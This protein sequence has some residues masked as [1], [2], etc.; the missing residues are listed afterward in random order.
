MD[1]GSKAFGPEDSGFNSH[2][3]DLEAIMTDQI[4]AETYDLSD[5]WEYIVTAQVKLNLARDSYE[6][7]DEPGEETASLRYIRKELMCVYDIMRHID[8]FDEECYMEAA[9]KIR[10]FISVNGSNSASAVTI[11]SSEYLMDSY[12]HK[13]LHHNPA[14]CM[15]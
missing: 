14:T 12:L 10:H 11:Q 9:R 6:K 4:E 7:M 1:R 8:E 13:A 2:T 3:P 15:Y 5:E